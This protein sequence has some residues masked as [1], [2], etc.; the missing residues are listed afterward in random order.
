MSSPPPRTVDELA[1][2]AAARAEVCALGARPFDVLVIGGGI[3]GAGVARDAALR[4]MTVAL[5]EQDDFA[6]GTSSR[7]SRLV[8]GGVRYLEHGQLGLV[9]ESSRER[10]ILLRIAPHLVRPLAFTWPVYLGARVPRWQLAAALTM[11]DVLALFRNVARHQR[12][13]AREVLRYEPLVRQDA[14]RGGARYFDAATD[15]ARLT[16][17]TALSARDAG[18]VLVTHARVDALLRDGE[19]VT[20]A[21]VRDLLTGSAPIDVRARVVVNATGPWSD[22]VERLAGAAAAGVRGS[23]GSHVAVPRAR[24]GNVAALT[25]IAPQDGRVMFVLPAGDFTIIGT[26]D[27][28]ESVTPEEVRATETDVRYLLDAANHFFPAAQL[29]RGDVV[30]AWAGLR[31]LAVDAH[32]RADAEGGNASA[33]SR[34][35]AITERAPGLVTVTGGKLTTYRAMAQQVT[36]VVVR[37]LGNARRRALTA[38]Q[39]LPGGAGLDVAHEVADATCATGDDAIAERLV[40]AHGTGWRDVWRFAED[41]R[42][43]AQRVDVSRPY[44]VAELRYAVAHEMAL[45]LGDL[46]IRRVPLA[47]ET[48]D[49]GRAAARRIAPSVATWLGWDAPTMERMIGAYDAEAT[50]IFAIDADHQRSAP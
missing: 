33:A 11:Y 28:F 46:L 10:R 23:K 1:V 26:T 32:T 13:S 38:E 7:S 36:E 8:H 49:N 37:V 14:L 3:T 31:P 39:T 44:L 18:A 40:H 20:G 30:A 22:R 27:T 6:S 21:R 29:T 48:A 15:D 50:R 42:A 41:D 9:F 25:L 12:L 35:H 17:T 4:G 2:P 16:L 24:V 19:R 45:T 5:V 43:L 34:E 47:F